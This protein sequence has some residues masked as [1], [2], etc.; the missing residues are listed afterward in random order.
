MKQKSPPDSPSSRSVNSTRRCC[1]P[2]IVVYW[3]LTTRAPSRASISISYFLFFT[4]LFDSIESFSL[5]SPRH[6]L[7]AHPHLKPC[8]RFMREKKCSL[9]TE[10]SRVRSIDSL[11]LVSRSPQ[12]INPPGR[13][14]DCSSVQKNCAAH[15]S[16]RHSSLFCQFS[17]I[18]AFF[19]CTRHATIQHPAAT[20][21][22]LRPNKWS[23]AHWI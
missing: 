13:V 14:G 8:D 23:L 18:F 9:S 11:L 5:S 12:S 1:R 16:L 19:P 10:L 6:T 2:P 7:L 3:G 20:A 17:L 4:S 15:N 21:I 22:F